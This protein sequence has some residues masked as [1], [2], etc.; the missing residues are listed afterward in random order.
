MFGHDGVVFLSVSVY[1][2]G[3][4]TENV[5]YKQS[6]K[7]RKISGRQ[8]AGRVYS[9]EKTG[10]ARQ[11]R[12]DGTGQDW[13]GRDGA[14]RGCFVLVGV[15]KGRE[16]SEDRIYGNDIEWCV[17]ALVYYLAWEGASEGIRS[18]TVKSAQLATADC[19]GKFELL[20][21]FQGQDRGQR[22]RQRR[23]RDDGSRFSQSR[24]ERGRV[25]A[26]GRL[27]WVPRPVLKDWV[28][29]GIAVLI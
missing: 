9:R 8:E 27:F 16:E 1:G 29:R 10:D 20:E 5:G 11:Q 12:S 18:R 15:E 23:L 22:S 4:E 2:V 7:Q 21:S 13:T 14:R 6:S 24:R 17:L 19:A 3:G 28:D 25:E 26:K